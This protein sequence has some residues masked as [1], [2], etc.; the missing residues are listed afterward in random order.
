MKHNLNFN[1]HSKCENL[2]NINLSSVDELLLFTREYTKSIE[3]LVLS[4]KYFSYSTGLTMNPA[5]CQ[6]YYGNMDEQ[7]KMEIH[8]LTSFAEGPLPFRYLGVPFIR[9]KFGCASGLTFT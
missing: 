9:I 1:F 4:F 5:K 6:V 7:T 2:G 3:H 8:N